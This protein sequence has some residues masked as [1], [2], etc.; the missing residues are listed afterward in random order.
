MPRAR[1]TLIAVAITV[2]IAVLLLLPMDLPVTVHARGRLLPREAWNLSTATDGPLV[3][4][5][6]NNLRGGTHS[7]DLVAFGR[8]DRVRIALHPHIFPG[9]DIAERDTIAV[10]H[11]ADARTRWLELDAELSAAVASLRAYE[12]GER[13]SVIRA[14]QLSVDRAEER[15]EFGARQVERLRSLVD[16]GLAAQTELDE[17]L[18]DLRTAEIR[19][20]RAQANLAASQSGVKEEELEWRRAVVRGLQRQADE[21]RERMAD[22][23]IVAPFSGRIGVGAQPGDLVRLESAGQCVVNLPMPYD[24][25]GDVVAGA[26]ITIDAAGVAEPIAARVHHVGTT[27]TT[28]NG[29]QYVEAIGIVDSCALPIGMI[30]ECEVETARLRPFDYVVR[31]LTGN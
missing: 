19:R 28:V 25:A 2:A 3:A 21:A 1:T 6:R 23:V 12:S 30:V 14:A 13:E 11:S 7:A 31:L 16:R 27:M 15:A 26:T 17:E 20:E 29:R 5:R 24:R 18:S 9:A 4:T 10:V 22:S 8:G